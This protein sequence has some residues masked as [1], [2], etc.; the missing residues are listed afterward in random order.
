MTEQ[1]PEPWNQPCG[2]FGKLCGKCA[3]K[4]TP[5]NSLEELVRI[6][7]LEPARLAALP[8][9]SSVSANS[10]ICA[11]GNV[12]SGIQS[13][14]GLTSHRKEPVLTSVLTRSAKSTR[15]KRFQ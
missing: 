7:G 3:V 2:L 12:S 9:Q 8:P 6:A 10:T 13:F 15:G 14:S 1:R 4:H 5:S 11:H